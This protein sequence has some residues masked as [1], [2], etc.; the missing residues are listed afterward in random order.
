MKDLGAAKKILGMEMEDAQSMMN[1]AKG[2]RSGSSSVRENECNQSVGQMDGPYT[3][4]DHDGESSEMRSCESR[5][6]WP[7]SEGIGWW[8]CVYC[9]TSSSF[10]GEVGREPFTT[11]AVLVMDWT[12]PGSLSSTP[13]T[14]FVMGWLWG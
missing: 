9:T 5:S 7:M 3:R 4:A 10:V 2:D 12:N 14:V 1:G 6:P 11:V 8:V 13:W